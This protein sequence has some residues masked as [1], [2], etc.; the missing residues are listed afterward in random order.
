MDESEIRIAALETLA[1]ELC[2]VLLPGQLQAMTD[3]LREGIATKGEPGYGSDENAAR[4]HALQLVDD[5][6]RR[7]DGF[8]GGILIPKPKG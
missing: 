1:I 7:A 5:G 4:L 8:T 2:A 3:S 6:M